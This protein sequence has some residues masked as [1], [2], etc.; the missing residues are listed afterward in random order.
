MTGNAGGT[1]QGVRSGGKIS[2]SVTVTSS[3]ENTTGEI[4][5]LHHADPARN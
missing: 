4:H 5:T 2:V 3:S 1:V